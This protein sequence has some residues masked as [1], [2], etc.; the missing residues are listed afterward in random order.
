MRIPSAHLCSLLR[1]VLQN[2]TRATKQL[3]LWLPNAKLADKAK[4]QTYVFDH[5]FT[6]IPRP[7]RESAA[8]SGSDT[9]FATFSLSVCR[10]LRFLFYLKE[11]E[12]IKKR[13][14]AVININNL[15][16]YFFLSRARNGRK[17]RRIRRMQMKEKQI[18]M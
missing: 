15:I 17:A 5:L 14:V 2:T 12:V 18:P 4:L 13:L 9:L 1:S 7:R 10:S 8:T 11:H 6:R 16:L 3:E